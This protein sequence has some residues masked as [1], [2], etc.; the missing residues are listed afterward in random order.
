[1]PLTVTLPL[2]MSSSIS[3]REP[4]PAMA[5]SLCNRCG[6]ALGSAITGLD[7]VTLGSRCCLKGRAIKYV[8][9]KGLKEFQLA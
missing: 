5:N 7:L 2:A 3:R 1:M 4:S 9:F 6:M 8:S